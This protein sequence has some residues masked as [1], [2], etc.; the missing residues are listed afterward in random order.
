MRVHEIE[1]RHSRAAVI[2]V[3][4]PLRE[5]KEVEPMQVHKIELRR[6]HATAD[7]LAGAV[8]TAPSSAAWPSARLH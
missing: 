1:L 7:L 6:G 4:K 3:A 2:V 5:H 8:V